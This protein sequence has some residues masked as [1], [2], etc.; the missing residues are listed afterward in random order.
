MKIATVNTFLDTRR[1][2]ENSK[3][4]VKITISHK[5][6][7]KRYGTAIDLTPAEWK[8]LNILPSL[9]VFD[10]A[11]KSIKD[12]L[13]NLV[14]DAKDII[15][16]L[17]EFSFFDFENHFLGRNKKRI[18]SSLYYLF[19]QCITELKAQGQFDRA[20]TYA[21]T[22]GLLKDFQMN[23]YL[24]QI[25]T[26]F[27]E[28]FERYIKG[29]SEGNKASIHTH[30]YNF[31]SFII[32]LVASG[33]LSEE[34]CP[35]NI[36]F[37]LFDIYIEDL[38]TEERFGTAATFRYTQNMLKTV[39]N[40]L[41]LKHITSEF[42]KELETRLRT[43]KKS[44]ATIGIHFRNIRV[45][46]N[47]AIKKQLFPFDKY[48]FKGYAI[49]TS[50][51]IKKALDDKTISKLLKHIPQNTNRQ[52][53]LDFW[54]FS[55]LGNGMNIKDIALLRKDY[56]DKNFFS[57]QRAKTIRTRKKDQRPI[58]VAIHPR[59]R[60]IINRWQSD[61]SNPYL[62]PI[63]KPGLPAATQYHRIH[64]FTKFVNAY[65]KEIFQD[66]RIS[67]PSFVKPTTITARHSFATRLR[68]K[69]VPI[70]EIGEL[71]GHTDPKTTKNYLDSFDDDHLIKRS[72]LLEHS[73]F[74]SRIFRRLF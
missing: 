32:D 6:Y 51:N 52:K 66:L 47:V 58:K 30:L 36:F 68:S 18:K 64:S 12:R 39:K 46:V 1:K 7:K 8:M 56:L 5:C 2:K 72:R 40:D 59:A 33:N 74:F 41:R 26:Q 23:A 4:P 19:N 17:E 42:L 21:R 29:R 45:V 24:T 38:K 37:E 50:Q 15:K 10:P 61:V 25:N 54:I 28:E 70:D 71:L 43:Q 35:F 27:L 49:P 63:L 53:A 31:K 69:G 67:L 34:K 65:M 22:L 44:D 73:N 13:D 3:Y 48:P 16:N 55:Y 20:K 60:K 11:L 14:T 62:F 57:F 9:L